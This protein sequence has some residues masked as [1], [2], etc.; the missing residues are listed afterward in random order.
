MRLNAPKKIVWILSFIFAVVSLVG[1]F[2]ALP[3]I[4]GVLVYWSMFV[5]WLL[6]FLATFLKG[7]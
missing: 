2:V 7:M 1:N 4:N 5:A 3:L 6:L